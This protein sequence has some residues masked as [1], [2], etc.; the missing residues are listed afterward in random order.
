MCPQL[1]S[2]IKLMTGDF[3]Y[4]L[5]SANRPQY[6][7]QPKLTVILLGDKYPG[8]AKVHLQRHMLSGEN[9]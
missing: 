7:I 6:H 4:A 9:N 3:E 8:E 1:I 2:S 5:K